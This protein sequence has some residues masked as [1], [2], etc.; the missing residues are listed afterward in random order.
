MVPPNHPSIL[1]FS[2]IFTIHFGVPLF[3]E[4]SIYLQGLKKRHPQSSLLEK[5][6]QPRWSLVQVS[7]LKLPAVFSP[8]WV[9]RFIWW[10]YNGAV[11]YHHPRKI[12]NKVAPE[13]PKRT[14]ENSKLGEKNIVFQVYL[15]FLDR[16]SHQNPTTGHDT[17]DTWWRNPH[18]VKLSL[19]PWY[20]QFSDLATK[21]RRFFF[22]AE[23]SE[24]IMGI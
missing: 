20:F 23:N 2:I 21:I 19:E 3:S 15:S 13:I 11:L 6:C 16:G 14:R 24:N 17:N 22:C 18:R 1:R 5:G 12:K 10:I 4:T 7:S 8:Q 9:R